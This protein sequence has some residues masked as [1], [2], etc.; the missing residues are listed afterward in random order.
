MATK[1]KAAIGWHLLFLVPLPLTTT[2]LL[3]SLSK[4]KNGY[5]DMY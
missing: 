2:G 4:H 3:S 1:S 5:H